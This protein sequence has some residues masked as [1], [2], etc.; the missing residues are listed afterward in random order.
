MEDEAKKLQQIQQ[1][2]NQVWS[3]NKFFD[4]SQKVLK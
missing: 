3:L 2:K 4:F 1:A